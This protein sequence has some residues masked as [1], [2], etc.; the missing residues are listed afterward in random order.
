MRSICSRPFV[1]DKFHGLGIGLYPSLI[2]AL[3][4]AIGIGAINGFFVA[5]V[6]ISSFVATLGML[7][8]LD[9]LT[10][11]ISHST[12]V[13]P[14]PGTETIGVTTFQQIF[15]AGPTPS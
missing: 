9:G 12:P 14:V 10:L 4:V 15:G 2:A 1:W 3:I 5:Y 7:F 11:I 6:G 13:S 8:M